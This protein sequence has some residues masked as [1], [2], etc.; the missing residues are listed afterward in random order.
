MV[1]ESS[2]DDLPPLRMRSEG[3]VKA[4]EAPSSA[5]RTL[6]LLAYSMR[7]RRGLIRVQRCQCGVIHQRAVMRRYAPLA[8][9]PH[10]GKPPRQAA[11][12]LLAIVR[13]LYLC[14]TTLP[15]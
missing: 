8:Y 2:R 7:V 13:S 3:A 6:R 9:R 12:R 15:H 1:H 5:R 4:V 10:R 11:R 14:R